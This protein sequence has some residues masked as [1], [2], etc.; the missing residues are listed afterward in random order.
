MKYVKIPKNF[1]VGGQEVS[2][3][4]VERCNNNCIGECELGRG[5]VDIAYAYSKDS[6]QSEGSKVNTFYHELTHA[7][8]TTAGYTKL[9]NDE[10]FVCTFSSFLCEAMKNAYFKEED[11]EMERGC[12]R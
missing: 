2:V 12:A 10:Q 9:N 8:L 11:D 7:I 4:H 3:N 6:V 5:A 1:Q